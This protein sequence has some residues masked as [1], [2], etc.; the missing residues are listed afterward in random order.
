MLLLG[1]LWGCSREA[2]GTL[3]IGKVGYAPIEGV[4]STGS[5]PGGQN[6]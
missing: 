2:R 3:A 6:F 4:L 5:P 1:F